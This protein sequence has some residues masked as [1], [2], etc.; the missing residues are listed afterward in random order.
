M[1][2]LD[3]SFLRCYG[4]LLFLHCIRASNTLATDPLQRMPSE[5]PVIIDAQAEIACD[6][7]GKCCT[8]TKDV[9]AQHGDLF[10]F[11]DCLSSFFS[12][13]LS[14]PSRELLSLKALGNVRF[15]TPQGVGS[16][17]EALYDVPQ[18]TLT[19]WGGP[20]KL[21]TPNHTLFAQ[22][23]SYNQAQ[24]CVEAVGKSTF[25]QKE[26]T[27]LAKKL[28]AFFKT[29]KPIKSPGGPSFAETKT[30]EL[31]HVIAQ[32]NVRISMEDTLV[33]GDWGRYDA[34]TQQ[35]IL[36]GNVSLLHGDH[37]VKGEQAR[38][39]LKQKKAVVEHASKSNP[40]GRVQ[41]ILKP[42][43]L[44]KANRPLPFKGKH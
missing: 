32:G 29:G 12:K 21:E 4:F 30:W 8:A 43:T 3:V 16:C 5:L 37:L 42:N 2:R 39:D 7:L 25:I 14:D 6:D 20:A 35:A 27:L 34:L 44:K 19:M 22:K 10:L 33:I 13:P 18:E 36:R 23:I 40:T 24:Q 17:E 1:S 9:K 28:T 31:D 26:S 38:V 11:T 15:K 41:A